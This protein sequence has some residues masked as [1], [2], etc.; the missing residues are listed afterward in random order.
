MKNKP[1]IVTNIILLC[2]IIAGLLTFMVL[3]I[4]KKLNFWDFSSNVNIN[5]TYQA[6]EFKSFLVNVKSYDVYIKEGNADEVKVEV[7]GREKAKKDIS[8]E[9]N[10]NNLEIRQ[11]GSTVC[12]G[13]CFNDSKIVITLSKNY[14]YIFDI[15]STSGNI[16]SDLDF[17]SD[18]SI[19]SISGD[20][21]LRSV[22]KADI[23]STSG[24]ITLNKLSEG[25]IKSTSGDIEVNYIQNVNL[26][27]TSGSIDINKWIGSG[28]VNTTSGDIEVNSFEITNNTKVS[29]TSGDVDIRLKNDAYIFAQTNSGDKKI[30]ASK[31]EYELNIKTTSGDITVK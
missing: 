10:N 25:S 21:S 30:K 14:D 28:V 17:N 24:N 31:G 11:S 1:L 27:S 4:T 19:T 3:G 2:C 26:S 5:E 15:K 22:L 12:F 23:K 7:I 13:F 20:I 8:V 18:S 6:T 9:L 16:V 29:S